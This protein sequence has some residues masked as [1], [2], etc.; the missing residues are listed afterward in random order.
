VDRRLHPISRFADGLTGIGARW[1]LDRM[2]TSKAL[3]LPSPSPSELA[4]PLEQLVERARGYAADSRAPATRRAYLHD[5]DGFVA[6]CAA[7]GLEPLP[8]APATVAVYLSALADAGRRPTS[9]ERALSG[10]AHA[11]RTRGLVW[12]RAHPTI[13]EVMGGIKRR[14]GMEPAQKAPVQDDELEQLLAVLDAG[15]LAD[16]RDRA[17]L[18]MG[19]WGAFRRSELVALTCEDLSRSTDGLTVRLRRSKNDQEG[20]GQSKGVP[21][22]REP[23]LC[24]VRALDAWL[25]AAAITTGPLFR[26]VDQRGRVS[27]R[28]LCDKT[29]SDIVKRT[30][31]RAGLDPA[32]VAGH[33]LR[34]GFATTAA[35]AGRSLDAIMR[36]TLHRCPKVARRYVRLAEVFQGNA[37]VG[38]R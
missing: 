2:T 10:I 17:L 13:T 28:A 27:E 6:W 16:L 29:V 30:A 5:W 1:M 32:R 23:K 22:A 20:H 31:G 26:G 33:S 7:H 35:K 9:I 37:A 15:T 21:Y 11:H 38:L 3:V 34:A 14:H 24:A 4:A 18:T 8:A 12:Q 36:Q 25:A 19:W